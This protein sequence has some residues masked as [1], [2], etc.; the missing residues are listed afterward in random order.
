MY[1][2]ETSIQLTVWTVARLKLGVYLDERV[3]KGPTP[4]P[5]DRLVRS[6][7]NLSCLQK[8]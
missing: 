3:E 4:L 2:I 5:P 8:E 6:Q 7:N 1:C